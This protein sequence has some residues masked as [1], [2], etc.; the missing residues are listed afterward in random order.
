M[1]HLLLLIPLVFLTVQPVSG[2]EVLSLD[3]AL[4]EALEHN[5]DIRVQR[6]EQKVA[7][8]RVTRGEAGQLPTVSL[9]G[10]LSGSRS[11]QEL[12]PGS[13]FPSTSGSGASPGTFQFDGVNAAT[14]STGLGAQWVI[15]DGGKGKLRYETLES[16]SRIT[17]LQLQM[18]MERTLLSVVRHY[19][20]TASLQKALSLQSSALEQSRDRYRVTD[21]RRSYGQVN[22]QQYLQALADLKSDSTEYRD[23][24]LRYESAYREL[25]TVIGWEDPEIRPLEEEIETDALPPFDELLSSLESGNSALNVRQERI[26]QAR[27]GQEMSRSGFLPKVTASARYGYQ[28]QYASD[29]LF[30]SQEQLGLTGGLSLQIPLFSG[31]RNRTEVQRAQ[32]NLRQE[33]I[34]FE[35]SRQE[36]RM[37]FENAWSRLEHLRQQLQSEQ[38]NLQV[39]ERNYDRARD[40]F[41]RGLLTGVELRSAQLSL[42]QARLRLSEISF[43]IVQTTATIHYLT[44]RF[45]PK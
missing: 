31:G 35:G 30:E 20:T 4:Q 36:I 22:E 33:K 10:E 42:Q 29:G 3:E 44:G 16:G 9:G 12:V 32:A 45:S 11:D 28:Y 19:L 5:H 26:E 34:R 37:Q 39:Y 15:Y 23:L 6:I 27:M 38:E 40:A 1:K 17:D 13:L 14:I 43:G 8:D 7:G 41:S 2:Q 18:E 25:H 24:E 21:T